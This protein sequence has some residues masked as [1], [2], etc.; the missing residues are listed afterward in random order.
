[1]FKQFF[2]KVKKSRTAKAIALLSLIAIMAVSSIA[3]APGY[4]NPNGPQNGHNWPPTSPIKIII[5]GKCVVI[6][7][8]PGHW[9][10]GPSS[11]TAYGGRSGGG[12]VQPP[13]WWIPG[14]VLESPCPKAIIATSVNQ[15]FYLMTSPLG[16][17]WIPKGDIAIIAV[18]T[19]GPMLG[20]VIDGVKAN[21]GLGGYLGDYIVFLK[22]NALVMP[23]LIQAQCTYPNG[24]FENSLAWPRPPN[25]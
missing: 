13:R 11:Y 19:T 25:S 24:I 22:E 14:E 2:A 3:A 21:P 4:G 15:S 1:M 8:I 18:S 20:C 9:E 10:Y 16:A 17:S 23:S 6:V 12:N 7:W 5:D